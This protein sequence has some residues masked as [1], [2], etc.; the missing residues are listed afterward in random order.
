M[1][2]SDGDH[3]RESH[4]DQHCGRRGC[5]DRGQFGTATSAALGGA[6]VTDN[7]SILSKI[8]RIVIKGSVTAPATATADTYGIVAQY[9]AS[10]TVDGKVEAL[11]AGT[12]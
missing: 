1:R 2:K 11:K 9:I 3:W 7:L 6:G 5:R 10:A 4:G 12:G 8:S